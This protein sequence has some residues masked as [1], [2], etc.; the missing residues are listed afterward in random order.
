VR[1]PK[2]FFALL[3]LSV[4]LCVVAGDAI[5]ALAGGKGI[6]RLDYFFHSAAYALWVPLVPFAVAAAKRFAPAPGRMPATIGV[7]CV[8]GLLLSLATLILHKLIFCG[9][10]SH[11]YLRCVTYLRLE[12]WVARWLILAYFVYGATVSGVWLL[13]ALDTIRERELLLAARQ[14]ELSTAEVQ[15]VHARIPPDSLTAIFDTISGR[16]HTDAGGAE[17]MIVAAGAFLRATVRVIRADEITLADDVEMLAA[18]AALESARR[19]SPVLIE[20][21]L[22]PRWCAAAIAAPLLQPAAARLAPVGSVLITVT[23][24]ERAHGV[25]LRLDCSNG[26]TETIFLAMSA[27]GEPA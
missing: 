6:G 23:G 2:L 13:A 22:D 1:S 21:E 4:A 15:L 24:E 3:W 19:E 14:R 25:A 18:W 17:K 9:L 8:I 12:S 10:L 5:F 16:L 26:R 7:H 11:D 27:A 20:T